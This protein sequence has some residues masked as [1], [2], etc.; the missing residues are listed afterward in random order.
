MTWRICN[1]LFIPAD[2]LMV[3]KDDGNPHDPDD[4]MEMDA[5]LRQW[6]GE[7]GFAIPDDE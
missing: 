2:P 6:E 5:A 4:E 7:G 3:L 1:D